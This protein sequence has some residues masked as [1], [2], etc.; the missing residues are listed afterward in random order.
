MLVTGG[1]PF[2]GKSTTPINLSA[3]LASSGDRVILVE[4]DSRR[5]SIGAAL[6]LEGSS[7]G[8]V[9]MNAEMPQ[10][11]MLLASGNGSAPS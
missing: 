6:N 9:T 10:L 7:K 4:G 8:L 11:R 2:D 3:A 1:S 5:P